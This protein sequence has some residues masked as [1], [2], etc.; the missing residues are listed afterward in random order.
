[1]C[2]SLS[3]EPF[4]R[5]LVPKPSLLRRKRRWAG[6]AILPVLHDSGNRFAIRDAP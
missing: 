3:A 2:Q 6:L 4:R 5:N 1:M